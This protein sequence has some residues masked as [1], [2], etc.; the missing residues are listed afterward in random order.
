[1]TESKSFWPPLIRKFETL[2]FAAM[3]IVIPF[4]AF[5]VVDTAG[6][7]LMV[8]NTAADLV[9]DIIKAK[10]IAR[11]FNVSVTVTSVPAIGAEP[12]CYLIQSNSKTIEQV[13]LPNGVSIVGSITFNEDGLPQ[14]PAPFIIT[15]GGRTSTVQVNREGATSVQ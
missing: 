13:Q 2:V 10:E 12:S 7:A 8:Q 5:R 14:R 1:M 6:T 15:K 9:K 11:N 4:F 3:L